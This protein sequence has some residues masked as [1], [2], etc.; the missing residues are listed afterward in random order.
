MSKTH[1]PGNE[2]EQQSPEQPASPRRNTVNVK[3]LLV[4]F[5]PAIVFAILYLNYKPAEGSLIVDT[6]YRRLKFEAVF[7][8]AGFTGKAQSG[9]HLIVWKAGGAVKAALFQAQVSD[10][11]ILEAM[12]RFGIKPGNNLKED[13]WSC[14]KDPEH[15]APDIKAEGPRIKIEVLWPGEKEFVQIHKLFKGVKADD[16]DFRFAGNK[17][18]IEVWNSGCVACLYS[19]P[20]GK[21]SNAAYSVRD[22]V[23]KPKR[24]AELADGLPAKGTRAIIYLTVVE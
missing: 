3:A 1:E 10:R 7:N 16:M 6:K 23:E 21:L 19:C 14:R 9:Y 2:S 8:P 4:V 15:P 24:F 18:M 12:G 5:A 11:K 13:C 22:Y 20:G 17:S